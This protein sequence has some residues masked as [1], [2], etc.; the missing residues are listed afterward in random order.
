M[1]LTRFA[2]TRIQVTL[3]L[4]VFVLVG[5]L[6]SYGNLPK[7]EDPGFTIRTV[8]IVTPFPGASPRRVEQLVSAPI[9]EE[10]QQI[11]EL[12]AIRSTSRSGTSVVVVEIQDDIADLDPVHDE[13]RQAVDDAQRELPADAHQSIVNAD[14]ATVYGVV[15]ALTYEGF[16]HTEA[17][18]TARQVKDRLL[19]LSE[20]SQVELFGVQERRIALR[21]DHG[22]LARMGLTPN[23]LAGLLQSTNIVTPGGEL[24]VGAEV[25]SIEPSGSFES[26]GDVAAMVVRLP[27]GA[28]VSLSD[29]VDV[30]EELATPSEPWASYNGEPAVFIGVSQRE[31]GDSARF[32]AESRA[33]VAA[34]LADLPLG[35]ELQEVNFQPDDVQ[36]KIDSF[37]SSLLQSV[38][39]VFIVMMLFLGAR[40]GAI[41]ASLIPTVICAT[42]LIMSGFGIGV[43]QMSLA[44]LLI[45]LGMLVDNA[46]V[47]AENTMVRMQGG[48]DAVEATVGAAVELRIP[49][50]VSSLTTCAA[51]LPVYLAPGGAS[52]FV[53]PIFKVVTI[54]LLSSWIL[55]T[56]VLPA[57]CVLF[58]PDSPPTRNDATDTPAYN[59][60][61]RVIRGALRHRW[62]ALTGSLL[63]LGAGL[64]GFRTVPVAFFPPSEKAAFTAQVELPAGTDSPATL[65]ALRRL[66]SF[67]ETELAATEDTPGVV[68]HAAMQ[69]ASMPRFSLTYSGPDKAPGSL[70]LLLHTTDRAGV[71]GWAS[72][73]ERWVEAELPGATVSASP[74]VLGPGGAAPI[75]VELSSTDEDALLAA[76]EQT[77]A[78][79]RAQ[80]GVRNV[81]DDWGPRT[82]KLS[83]DIDPT[84]ARLAGVTNQDVALSLLTSLSG[85]EATELR[86]GDE[87]VPVE[88]LAQ[89]SETLDIVGLQ[90]LTVFGQAGSVA[91]QQVAEVDVLWD[92]GLIRRK[93][94]RRAI[95]VSGYPSPGTSTSDVQG[96][97]LAWVDS[98][99]WPGVTAQAAGELADSAEANAKLMSTVPLVFMIV[100][101]LLMVQFNDVRKT[102]INL[103]VLPFSLTGVTVG[104][105]LFNSY[106]GF[107]TLLAIISLFGIVLNNGNVLLDRIGIELEEGREPLDAIVEASVQRLRPILLTTATT[108]TGLVPLYLGGG[109]MFEPLAVTLMV[110][111]LFGTVL[112]LGLVPVMYAVLFR[113]PEPA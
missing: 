74:L 86:E 90:N 59:M 45:A 93:A 63:F 92:F 20:A 3:T 26:V 108:V 6:L 40:T 33:A 102:F 57:I 34:F 94:R 104:L 46:I 83:V 107:I 58:L 68:A 56:T 12:S 47:M 25:L 111:L 100:V 87:A 48:A 89:G 82:K 43:D 49:L 15:Y 36:V 22:R 7:A 95:E 2:V 17:V 66:D 103:A 44:A 69:G 21:F 18:A 42:F 61:R 113:V 50:L 84:R 35:L 99:A 37:V 62:A 77:V 91:L 10:L 106:F 64:A 71:E 76:S 109:P 41:V 105:L 28:L 19:L 39:I 13:I 97:L 73:L 65:D 96:A 38:T 70:A 79:L 54:A 67:I 8:S 51:F 30:E 85:V 29:I 23:Q 75:A 112:T 110:G 60:Y 81:A 53:G 52:E 80:P 16:T 32:G 14:V 72:V 24:S 5:G 4:L 31:A 9:E 88:L 55:A 11:P 1:N 27:D 78:W 101:L 98:Q